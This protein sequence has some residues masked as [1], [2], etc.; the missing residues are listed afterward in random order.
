MQRK[1][2]GKVI[3]KGASGSSLHQA[4]A[5]RAVSKDR[6]RL[7]E[8]Q[9][10]G[11]DHVLGFRQRRSLHAA[12]EIVDEL[13]QRAASGRAEMNEFAPHHRE[14]GLGGGERRIRSADQE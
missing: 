5:R 3:G 9:A 13:H 4:T 1:I 7:L 10:A 8:V 11:A 12:H 2:R 14:H 6:E